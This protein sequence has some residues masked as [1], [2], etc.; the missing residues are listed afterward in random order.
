MEKYHKINSLFKRDMNAPKKPFL[1]GEWASPE[2]GFLAN[3]VWLWTEKIDG[4]NIRVGFDGATVAIGGRKENSQIP[5]PLLKALQEKYT[6]D[7]MKS[8]FPN[9]TAEEP[10]TLYGEGIGYRIQK[11]DKYQ[12]L[13]NYEPMVL[14]DVKIGQWW[15]SQEDIIDISDSLSVPIASTRGAGTIM[16][17]IEFVRGG[18]KSLFGDFTAEGLVLRPTVPLFSRNGTRIITKVKVRDFR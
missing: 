9:I 15:L 6:V 7:L 13:A 18:F 4:T 5:R 17:A 11:S 1:F 2:I 14:F 16:D 10:I 12:E 3:T 8:A